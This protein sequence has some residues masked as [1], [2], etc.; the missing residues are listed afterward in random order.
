MLSADVG[1]RR[2]A[3]DLRSLLGLAGVSGRLLFTSIVEAAGSMVVVGLVC[4]RR[5]ALTE[6]VSSLPL[7]T[8]GWRND[9]MAVLWVFRFF[10]FFLI[11]LDFQIFWFLKKNECVQRRA[12]AIGSDRGFD[13]SSEC[14]TSECSNE[15]GCHLFSHGVSEQSIFRARSR[16]IIGVSIG[17]ITY[18][19]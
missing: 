12:R 4:C 16:C 8:V 14:D 3:V 18:L 15:C 6:R 2:H 17:E 1:E 19:G 5:R 9:R 11:F 13:I 7:M 10:S